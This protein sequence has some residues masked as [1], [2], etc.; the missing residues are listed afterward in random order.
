MT[1]QL[2]L[3][4][5]G[6]L[7]YHGIAL[8]SL[9]S[10]VGLL[11]RGMFAAEPQALIT[12]AVNAYAGGLLLLCAIVTWGVLGGNLLRA[13]W[14]EAVRAVRHMADLGGRERVLAVWFL[15]WMMGGIWMAAAGDPG[16]A[17]IGVACAMSAL[18]LPEVVLVVRAA[19]E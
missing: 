3:A 13:W 9:G 19:E 8:L 11:S 4:I 6:R 17:N 14:R 12:S 16:A 15:L 1:T 10:F 5:R 7:K 18:I 2:E